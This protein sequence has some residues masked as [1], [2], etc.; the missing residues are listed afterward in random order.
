ML[1]EFLAQ[2]QLLFSKKWAS[3]SEGSHSMQRESALISAQKVTTKKEIINPCL[4]NPKQ[5]PIVPSFCD[6][7]QGH[8]FSQTLA[9]ISESV[10]GNSSHRAFGIG[11]LTEA[12]SL[13]RNPR[14]TF[15]SQ[16]EVTNPMSLQGGVC[17]EVWIINIHHLKA[18]SCS[19]LTKRLGF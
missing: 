11:T 7:F 6:R 15:L 12:C 13:G 5:N 14:V 2:A 16:R 9:R 10:Y 8:G 4:N 19:S 1:T 3:G 18:G 17:Q